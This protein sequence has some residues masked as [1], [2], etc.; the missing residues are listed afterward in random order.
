[1]IRALY[2]RY[3]YVVLTATRLRAI[4]LIMKRMRKQ[5]FQWQYHRPI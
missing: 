1:M 4:W 3:S 2:N 5:Q